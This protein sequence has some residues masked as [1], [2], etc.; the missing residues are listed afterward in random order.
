MHLYKYEVNIL[1]LLLHIQNIPAY[2]SMNFKY[3][4]S[5]DLK[6]YFL[7]K[8]VSSHTYIIGYY[9][10]LDGIT[11]WFLTLLTYV[12]YVKTNGLRT[13]QIF[14]KLF[15]ANLFI[16]RIFARRLLKGCHRVVRS[17][18]KKTGFTL[19]VTEIK[20]SGG[21]SS[22]YIS[23]KGNNIWILLCIKLIHFNVF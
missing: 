12:V 18:Y 22:F 13:Q 19:F 17:A 9:N 21:F 6:R 20:S 8:F 16:L 23:V 4:K 1:K 2:N 3:R 11:T 7:L 10:L 5:F 15:V 14:V